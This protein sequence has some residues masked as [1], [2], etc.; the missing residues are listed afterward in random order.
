MSD[1][2]TNPVESTEPMLVERPLRLWNRWSAVAIM[3]LFITMYVAS[4]IA[5][6]VLLAA[7]ASILTITAVT[8]LTSTVAGIGSILLANALLHKH[9]LRDLGFS[10]VSRRWLGLATL[11]SIGVGVVRAI[12]LDWLSVTF[13][14]LNAGSETLSNMLVFDE[15]AAMIVSVLLIST[16]VPLW[17]EIFFRGFIHN[18]LRNRLGMWAAILV[19]SL[20]F[21]I[22]HFIPLQIIG[23]FTLGILL[24][25]L[26]EK[27]GSLWLPIFAHALNNVVFGTIAQF[28]G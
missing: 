7:N 1:S 5:V 8:V 14:I 23:A 28:F 17:E 6:V 12:G 16:L 18:V 15:P 13:P 26:Y 21:G 11:L 19:S 20:L 25:W 9:S 3:T 2:I 27:S 4:Q 10:S 24:A 22:F